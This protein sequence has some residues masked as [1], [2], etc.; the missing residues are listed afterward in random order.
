M[1][2]AHSKFSYVADNDGDNDFTQQ[3]QHVGCQSRISYISCPCLSKKL[4]VIDGSGEE[5]V[6]MRTSL[7]V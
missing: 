7:V 6:G 3:L 5:M 2:Y 4:T 1:I